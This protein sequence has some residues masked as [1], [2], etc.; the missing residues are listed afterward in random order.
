MCITYSVQ[1]AHSLSASAPP[2]TVHVPTSSWYLVFWSS[3]FL[4]RPH[5]YL[6][7]LTHTSRGRA[8]ALSSSRRHS[9]QCPPPLSPTLLPHAPL[10]PRALVVSRPQHQSCPLP[11]SSNPLQLLGCYPTT[12]PTTYT[13]TPQ[14]SSSC[15]TAILSPASWAMGCPWAWAPTSS[16]RSA[17]RVSCRASRRTNTLTVGPSR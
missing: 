6:P 10:S 13:S 11:P 14:L 2:C 3:L 9:P 7:H 17:F 12:E 15:L 4:T 1:H 8:S 16:R 5:A